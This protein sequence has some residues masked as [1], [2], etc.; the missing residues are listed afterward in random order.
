MKNM[1]DYVNE[2]GKYPLKELP[3][4]EVDSLI[5]SQFAYL[6]YDGIVPSVNENLPSVVL[7]DLPS[8]PEFSNLFGDER[9]EKVN[10]ALFR[11]AADSSRFQNLRL[12]HY[13][14]IVDTG[15]EIQFS[16]VTYL[17]EDGLVY[18]AFRGT[19]ETIVGWKEDFNMA[20]RTPVPAQEK[21]VQYL[22]YAAAG[23]AGSF[24][25][26]GHSKGGNLAVYSAMKCRESVK[27]R[28]IRIYSHDGPGFQ[29]EVLDSGEFDVIKDRI[30][31]LVPHSSI[32]GM[33]LQ[34][35]ET[36]E[37][38]ECKSFGVMQHDPF[39]WLVEGAGFKKAGGLYRHVKMQDESV[40]QWISGMDKEQIREFVEQLFAVINAPGAA[41]LI[42][43]KAD[44][45]R[46]SSAMLGAIEG[47]DEK[48]KEM[49]RLVMK[50]LFRA[51]S[52]VMKVRLTEMVQPATENE[53]SL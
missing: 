41:T 24:I 2:Y 37:V 43:L 7:K 46:S 9:Y 49:M 12:N 35:Q 4:N 3:F 51:M 14:N 22:N 5:L 31:K 36:Y 18:I 50:N 17:L 23:I 16:A 52:D 44:W 8:H 19:D 45:K 15:W 32:I 10:R 26:G 20:F 29:Q 39:N 38:V 34:T 25:V 28:M 47:M 33:L 40:N 13:V 6:K 42:D 30:R 27:E 21:A 11:A 48:S 53:Q 1:I